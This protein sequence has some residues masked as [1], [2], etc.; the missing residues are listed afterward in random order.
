MPIMILL[1]RRCAACML[2]LAWSVFSNVAK[3]NALYDLWGKTCNLPGNNI[4]LKNALYDVANNSEK[5]WSLNANTIH[6]VFRREHL[7]HCET[8]MQLAR[9]VSYEVK[10]YTCRP[11][12][13]GLEELCMVMFRYSQF[14]MIGDSITRQMAQGLHMILSEDFQYG[15]FPRIYDMKGK[16][17]HAK[18]E[19]CSCDGQFSEHPDCRNYDPQFTFDDIH[20][21][22]YCLSQNS[23]QP[24]SMLVDIIYH[25][26]LV[27]ILKLCTPEDTRP[28]LIFFQG[29]S[30][31]D[32]SSY[33]YWQTFLQPMLSRLAEAKKKCSY[34]V[35][36]VLV[37]SGVPANS[38]AVAAKYPDQCDW[39]T[40]NFNR[41]M[42]K[43]LSQH[44]PEVVFLN[45]WNLTHEIML[46]NRTADGFHQLSDSN[47]IRTMM[48][49]NVAKFA[50]KTF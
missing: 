36:Y 3:F 33:Y 43:Y 2:L 6:D 15:G 14:M 17:Q 46:Q 7:P 47:L 29:G 9:S 32:T 26:R 20:K 24:F 38:A 18:D 11:E 1:M 27:D 25:R 30:H 5:I 31:F 35:K 12:W 49:L 48:V 4:I 44:F 23:S 16:R 34:A 13:I 41:D 28:K 10:S 22:E 37:Y 42:D 40:E 19:R 50:S 39:C 45:F 8:P 21:L